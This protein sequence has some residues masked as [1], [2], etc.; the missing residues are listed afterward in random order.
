MYIPNT[1]TIPLPVKLVYWYISLFVV[2]YIKPFSIK[3]ID[4]NFGL[5][6]IF[7]ESCWKSLVSYAATF[8]SK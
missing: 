7:T 5:P 2:A 8:F 3:N 1:D 6:K 4:V